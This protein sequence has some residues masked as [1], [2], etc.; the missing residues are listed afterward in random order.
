MDGEPRIHATA[1]IHPE[2]QV[3][4]DVVVGPYCIVGAEVTLGSG[5][6]LD[7]HVRLDGPM[8]VGSDNRFHHGAAV[9]G[10]PQD[11]KYNGARSYVRVGDE[12]VFREF[13]TVNRATDEGAETIIGSNNLLMAYVHVAHDCVIH[14][15]VILANSVNLAGHV[16]I[17]DHAIIGG[18]TPVHQF[19]RI[20]RYA[21]VGGGSRVP[22]DMPPYLKAA[23]NP[24]RVVGLN[25]VG[26][27]RKGFPE[28][29]R[30]A[31]KFAYRTL[32]RS[33][34]NVTQAVDRIREEHQGVPEVEQLLQFIRASNRGIV[35]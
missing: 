6:V 35:R 24:L 17:E 7:S 30:K 33:K 1:I 34:L 5:C 9:G 23:G 27:E 13:V 20:G 25:T 8:T 14:D 12:N 19:V 11:L 29:I 22:K 26:L 4:D 3:A 10:V 32:Y 31:L 16:E 18:V 28:E 21:I 15:H 2:A